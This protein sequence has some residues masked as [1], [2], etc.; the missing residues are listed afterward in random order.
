MRL[1]RQ[2]RLDG[3]PF[4]V[5]KFM[6][7]ILSSQFESLNQRLAVRLNAP[8]WRRGK[9]EVRFQGEADMNWARLGRLVKIDPFRHSNCEL[10]LR[11][12]QRFTA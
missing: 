10:M 12:I 2:H 3:S 11:F 9:P 5:G 6:R 1:V 8:S 4:V 7:M